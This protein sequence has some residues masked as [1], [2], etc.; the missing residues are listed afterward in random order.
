VLDIG[1]THGDDSRVGYYVGLVVSHLVS[2]PHQI[3][4]LKDIEAFFILYFPSLHS[5]L[6]ESGIRPDRTEASCP[7]WGGWPCDINVLFWLIKDILG[8]CTQVTS[9]MTNENVTI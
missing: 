6:L 1:V 3:L 4:D 2:N 7:H 8:L 5:F 9:M